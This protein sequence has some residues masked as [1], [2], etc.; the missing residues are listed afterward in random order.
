M[1]DSNIIAPTGD[2]RDWDLGYLR[3]DLGKPVARI[4]LVGRLRFSNLRSDPFR[5][6]RCA[7]GDPGRTGKVPIRS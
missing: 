1:A 2:D 7:S 6:L 4:I 5:T 3:L